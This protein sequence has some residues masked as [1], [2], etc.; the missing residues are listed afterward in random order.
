M[1]RPGFSETLRSVDPERAGRLHRL[2][3]E[4]H[5]A[6]ERDL[7]ETALAALREAATLAPRDPTI[8]LALGWRLSTTPDLAGARSA[9]ATYLAAQPTDRA[10]AR[11][12]ARL[13]TASEIPDG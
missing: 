10:I 9:L 2:F 6:E 11:L 4:F 7:P 5:A 1:R 3:E 13:G 12:A 8:A